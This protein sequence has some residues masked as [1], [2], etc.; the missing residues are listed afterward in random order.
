MF[1]LNLKEITPL[2]LKSKTKL[3]HYIKE[4]RSILYSILGIYLDSTTG[5]E[6]VKNLENIQNIIKQK[7][8]IVNII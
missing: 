3:I 5:F 6:E 2:L 4:Y 1:I 7:K 8:H